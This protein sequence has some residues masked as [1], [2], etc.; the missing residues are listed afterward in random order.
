MQVF[1]WK[2]VNSTLTTGKPSRAKQKSFICSSNLL[3]SRVSDKLFLFIFW[4]SM[5]PVSMVSVSTLNSVFLSFLLPAQDVSLR[6]DLQKKQ[7]DYSSFYLY[8]DS[9]LIYI[10]KIEQ[11]PGEKFLL[12]SVFTYSS[13]TSRQ[14]LRLQRS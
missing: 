11:K 9:C 7:E 12:A 3:S 2:G 1:I 14:E 5:S 8:S 10:P 13:V 6:P 4:R